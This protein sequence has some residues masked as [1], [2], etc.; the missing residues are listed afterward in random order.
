[1][2]AYRI[3]S[4]TIFVS[5]IRQTVDTVR[6]CLVSRTFLTP[7]PSGWNVVRPT[8]PMPL[9]DTGTGM[10]LAIGIL[11]AL[12]QRHTTSRGRR[13]QVAMQDAQLQYIRGAFVQ[14]ARSGQPAMRTGDDV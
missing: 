10:L 12:Y 2:C 5:E 4:Q 14:H 7:S 11:G 6:I 8:F 3:C 9:G 1:M 13:I